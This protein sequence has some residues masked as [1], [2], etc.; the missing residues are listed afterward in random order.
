MFGSNYSESNAEQRALTCPAIACRSKRSE[1]K[2]QQAKEK[3]QEREAIQKQTK[4]AFEKANKHQSQCSICS[5]VFHGSTQ[6]IANGL[7]AMCKN[8]TV[9][10]DSPFNTGPRSCRELK[11]LKKSSATSQTS[12]SSS[13]SST[14]LRVSTPLKSSNTEAG[15]SKDTPLVGPKSKESLSTSVSERKKRI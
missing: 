3:K 2:K 10:V 7:A 15:K 8:K 5:K 14:D 6:D 9:P 1:V 11:I 4:Q 13:S 12:S